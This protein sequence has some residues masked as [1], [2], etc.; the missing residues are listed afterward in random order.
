L[1][2]ANTPARHGYVLGYL[3][4]CAVA[5]IV[6]LATTVHGAPGTWSDVLN[7]LAVLVVYGAMGAVFC[8]VAGLPV[9][10]LGGLAVHLLC[11]RV[12]PQWVHVLVAA[13]VGV[14]GG[15]AYGA[16]LLAALGSDLPARDAVIALGVAAASGRAAVIPLVHGRR[17][18]LAP[19][20]VLRVL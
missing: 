10:L 13:I 8:L 20:T 4:S 6:L 7:A 16:P 12:G 2:S 15:L 3:V 1:R 17:R 11:R 18:R 5:P 9:G 19:D 14:V